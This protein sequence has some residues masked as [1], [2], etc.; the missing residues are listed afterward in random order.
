M[1]GL[2]KTEFATF[3]S[4]MWS[5]LPKDQTN[6]NLFE[7][8]IFFSLSVKCNQ[9]FNIMFPVSMSPL[10]MTVVGRNSFFFF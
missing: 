1:N 8:A 3:F 5:L 4:L 6:Q 9:V 10:I 2:N 7:G